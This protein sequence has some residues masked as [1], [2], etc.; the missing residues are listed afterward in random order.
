[1]LLVFPTGTKALGYKEEPGLD[2]SIY[3]KLQI[4]RNELSTF[5]N[6]SPFARIQLDRDIKAIDHGIDEDWWRPDSVKHFM[7]GQALLPDAKFVDVLV[8][9]DAKETVIL[10]LEWHET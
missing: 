6:A 9:L 8:D 4:P 10:Y 1:M 2:R 3:L 7:S 5:L